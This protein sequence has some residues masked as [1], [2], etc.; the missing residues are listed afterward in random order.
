MFSVASDAVD[1]DDTRM[2][3]S[4]K[5]NRFFIKDLLHEQALSF[6]DLL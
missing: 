3:K 4:G 2:R 6:G 1:E 5:R